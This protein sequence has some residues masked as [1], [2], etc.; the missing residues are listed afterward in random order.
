MKGDFSRST[1]RKKKHYRKV[2]V[3]QGRVQIDSDWNEQNDIQVEHDKSY[4]QDIIGKGGTPLTENQGFAI[5][6]NILFN[7]NNVPP[8]A[9]S[10]NSDNRRL[11]DFLKEEFGVGDWVDKQEFTRKKDDTGKDMIVVTSGA[12]TPTSPNLVSIKLDSKEPKNATKA[13]LAIDKNTNV[14][15][16]VV[17]N[18]NDIINIFA[19]QNWYRIGAGHY[20]VD[21]ILCENET[22]VDARKATGF[23]I[24]ECSL[25]LG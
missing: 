19:D 24:I 10:G 13:T 16:F 6:P 5:I 25:Q 11:K 14:H 18:E 4:L 2:N 23:T 1:F 12:T 21:G 20:Y 7:W 9:G 8:P 3:Q 15:E 22:E 17:K